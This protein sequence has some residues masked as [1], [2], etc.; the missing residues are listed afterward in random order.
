MV[1]VSCPICTLI[2]PHDF[3]S[4]NIE[5]NPQAAGHFL[6]KAYPIVNLPC[7]TKDSEYRSSNWN[8]IISLKV[9][10]YHLIPYTSSNIRMFNLSMHLTRSPC[11]ARCCSSEAG[12]NAFAR[13]SRI[14]QSTERHGLRPAEPSA[15]MWCLPNVTSCVFQISPWEKWDKTVKHLQA[16]GTANEAATA[17]ILNLVGS[18][19]GRNRMT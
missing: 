1:W 11:Q 7:W 13:R 14:F 15:R 8:R 3:Q 18:T 5:H 16:A 4:Q 2:T 19:G 6:N 10:S 12:S 17:E 9:M